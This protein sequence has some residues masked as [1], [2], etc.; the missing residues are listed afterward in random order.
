MSRA[1]CTGKVSFG[2]CVFFVEV[3]HAGRKTS[4]NLPSPSRSQFQMCA[5]VVYA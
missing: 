2:A 3:V 1:C 4:K 5:A